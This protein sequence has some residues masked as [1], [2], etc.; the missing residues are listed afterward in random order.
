[1]RSVRGLIEVA[2]RFTKLPVP[3]RRRFC[4]SR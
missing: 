4:F 1:M 2:A 3:P